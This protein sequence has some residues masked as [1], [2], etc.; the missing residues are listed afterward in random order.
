M[1]HVKEYWLILPVIII[2]CIGYFV[3]GAYASLI[4]GSIV[5]FFSLKGILFLKDIHYNGI[6]CLAKVVS[7]REDSEGNLIPIVEYL[8]TDGK[9]ITEEPLISGTT[10]INGINLYKE[11]INKEVLIIYHP[12]KPE[13]YV[14]YDRTDTSIGVVVF[15]M[16]VSIVFIVISICA[17]LGVFIVDGF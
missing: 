1:K 7:V 10:E 9:L 13:K 15:M 6:K 4:V 2:F 14:L 12:T 5:F 8:T 17:I 11:S 3:R 16:M